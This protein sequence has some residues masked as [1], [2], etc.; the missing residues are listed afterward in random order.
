ML[1]NFNIFLFQ[2]AYGKNVRELTIE[3]RDFCN[4]CNISFHGITIRNGFTNSQSHISQNICYRPALYY[5]WY[6]LFL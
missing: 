5:M 4:T 6:W 3:F 1:V 2:L